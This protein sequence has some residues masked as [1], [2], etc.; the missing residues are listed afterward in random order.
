MFQVEQPYVYLSLK[1]LKVYM[2]TGEA[3]DTRPVRTAGKV[4]VT[5]GGLCKALH[6]V[7]L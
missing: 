1:C 4:G 7:A 5:Q 2:E 6:K 3:L